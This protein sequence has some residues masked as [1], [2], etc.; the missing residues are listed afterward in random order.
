MEEER[1]KKTAI[2]FF[3]NRCENLW[4]IIRLQWEVGVETVGKRIHITAEKGNA[5]PS[6]DTV[7]SRCQ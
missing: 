7:H 4:W 3:L 1:R 2:I 5:D 6:T